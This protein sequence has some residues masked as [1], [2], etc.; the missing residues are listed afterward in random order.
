[1]KLPSDRRQRRYSGHDERTSWSGPRTLST[2]LRGGNEDR[3]VS[4]KRPP[5]QPQAADQDPQVVRLPQS[6]RHGEDER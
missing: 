1:M 5:R 4:S 6:S 3:H 2:C